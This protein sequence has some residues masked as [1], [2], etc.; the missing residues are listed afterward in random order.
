MECLETLSLA[1]YG[2]LAAFVDKLGLVELL[3][4]H[5]PKTGLHYVSSGQAAKAVILNSFGFVERRLYL[6]HEFFENLPTERLIGPGVCPEHLNDD[7]I[8]HLLDNLSHAKISLL[9][10][11]FVVECLAPFL[12]K[13]LVLH[14][15]ITKIS[16]YGVCY[17]T[18]PLR[19]LEGIILELKKSNA[20]CGMH[21]TFCI[22]SQV[23]GVL[24][25]AISTSCKI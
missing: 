8:G 12:P 17:K 15:D 1:H 25:Q 9:Y 7:V 16:V 2:I 5:L 3:D 6:F 10:E 21:P 11:R 24:C 13:S 22:N 14:G 20:E 4:R 23:A 19:P 18:V